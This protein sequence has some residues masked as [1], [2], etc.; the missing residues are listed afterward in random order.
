MSSRNTT[1]SSPGDRDNPP[2]RPPLEAHKTT[3]GGVLL[4]EADDDI[5]TDAWLAIDD[6]IY[7]LEVQ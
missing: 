1:P 2:E 6:P 3:S 5:E 7:A 4:R